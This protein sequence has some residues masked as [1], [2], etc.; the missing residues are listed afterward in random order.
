[1][2]ASVGSDWDGQV[3]A[4]MEVNEFEGSWECAEGVQVGKVEDEA[5][6]AGPVS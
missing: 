6:H 3:V 1:M 5:E 2:K 4:N